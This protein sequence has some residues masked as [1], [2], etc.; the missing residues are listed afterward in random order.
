M[1]D[2]A[3]L[4]LDKV[5]YEYRNKHQTVK[6]VNE[7]S[8][9]F[10]QGLFYAITGKSGSGKTTL[11]SL[12]VG[13]DVPTE[14]VIK[15]EGT[16]LE[17][18]NMDKYRRDC[19]SLIYQ[20]F[21]LFPLLNI[22]ENVM[23]PLKLKGQKTSECKMLA[24]GKL[25]MVGLDESYYKRYPSMLS[26]GEQQRVAIARALVTGSS[27]LLADE[28]TGNLD[29]ENGNNIVS[30]LKDLAHNNKFCVIVV[31]HDL[32]IA[33]VADKTLSLRDG[34]LIP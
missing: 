30:I 22:L 9:E 23:Y 5:S 34:R 3:I 14:G 33:S 31:T 18:M 24:M 25:K 4:Q 1:A 32:D 8:Y 2:M 19:V 29:T 26:G 12:M 15:Y 27:I 21:N 10:N 20:D 17:E 13:L 7:F 6:A 28:P 11:L 16:D